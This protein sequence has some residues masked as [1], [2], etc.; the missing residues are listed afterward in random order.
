M[1]DSCFNYSKVPPASTSQSPSVPFFLSSQTKPTLSNSQAK[2]ILSNSQAKPILPT[3]Q[4]KLD[5]PTSQT[6]ID[7]PTSQTK[8]DLPT[9]QTKPELPTSQTKPDLPTSQTTKPINLLPL[10]FWS[11]PYI[12]HSPEIL[13]AAIIFNPERVGE[14]FAASGQ[15]DTLSKSTPQ[16]FREPAL[17]IPLY[18][19]TSGNLPLFCSQLMNQLQGQPFSDELSKVRYA[20]SCLGPRALRKMRSH[21]L[22]LENPIVP[23]EIQNITEFLAALKQECGDPN[24]MWKA[25]RAVEQMKQGD[26]RFHDFITL[27]QANMVDSTYAEVDKD[28]W[29]KILEPR[30]SYKLSEILLTASDVPTDYYKFVAYLR[31]KDARIQELMTDFPTQSNAEANT[32]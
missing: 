10:K 28:T 24:L 22:H 30:L 14:L 13:D 1:G 3:S 27:F 19:G 21:F 15:K 6:K 7:L 9:S 11:L 29:K 18:D 5:L 17:R 8:P 32:P 26:M 2:P 23:M 16:V 20:Y 25:T 31:T 12:T 4:T